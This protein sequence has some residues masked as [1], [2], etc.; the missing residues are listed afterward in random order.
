MPTATVARRIAELTVARQ[1]C[2]RSNNLEWYER[3]G[4]ALKVL[5]DRLP[6]GSGWDLGTAYQE[7]QSTAS[8]LVFTGA[9]HHMNDVGMY[10]AW[11]EH[12]ITARMS[13]L[14]LDV[15][16]SGRDRNDVKEYLAEMFHAA[17][18][19]EVQ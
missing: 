11:T 7:E 2:Q 9:F 18:S 15:T 5:V 12:T 14:G 16:V 13:F 1:N 19:E 6:S 4:A 17:L 8:K 3:H 10:S